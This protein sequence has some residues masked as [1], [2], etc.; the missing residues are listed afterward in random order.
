[1]R[2]KR[3]SVAEVEYSAYKLA[4]SLMTYDEP[5]PAFNTRFPNILESCLSSP[6]Q[7]FNQKPLYKGL[8]GKAAILFYLMIKDHPFE[9]GNKRVAVMTLLYLLSKNGKWLKITNRNLYHIAVEVAES[10]PKD[11]PHIIKTLEQLIAATLV[12]LDDDV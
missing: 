4:K 8:I 11:H 3:V 9:N 6:F 10:K 7:S 12:N 1:M 5:L 2:I